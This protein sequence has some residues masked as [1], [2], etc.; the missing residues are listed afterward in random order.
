MELSSKHTRWLIAA[1]CS[2][3]RTE[4]ENIASHRS[5]PKYC[6]LSWAKTVLYSQMG[7]EVGIKIGPTLRKK[8]S[9]SWRESTL[10]R[11]WKYRKILL[12]GSAALLWVLR[13]KRSHALKFWLFSRR[14]CNCG[15]CKMQEFFWVEFSSL[16]SWLFS[17]CPVACGVCLLLMA[18]KLQGTDSS[19]SS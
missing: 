6:F 8:L 15:N 10:K 3:L 7:T 5:S 2:L 19:P 18:C 14:N 4:H 16:C 11:K 12:H 1:I 13:Q 17:T 9:R